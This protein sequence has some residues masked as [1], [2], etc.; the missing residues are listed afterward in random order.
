MEHVLGFQR[1]AGL[2][3]SAVA[4][5]THVIHGMRLWKKMSQRTLPSD[6]HNPRTMTMVSG[7]RGNLRRRTASDTDFG[8]SCGPLAN[9]GFQLA[10]NFLAWER[11]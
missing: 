2:S 8:H 1:N 9:R 4:A 10:A 5:V 6:K 3:S 7:A 11:V